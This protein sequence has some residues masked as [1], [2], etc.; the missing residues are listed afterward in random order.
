MIK[1]D[2]LQGK[3]IFDD[4]SERLTPALHS[5]QVEPCELPVH[6]YRPQ[7][8]SA[9]YIPPRTAG[10]LLP[11][12]CH[13]QGPTMLFT[14]RSM[15]LATHPGQISF[16]GGSIENCDVD[17]VAASVRETHEEVGIPPQKI[18]PL[19]VLDNFDTISGYR[20]VPV[21]G[22]VKTPVSLVL[23]SSEVSAAFE[24]PLAEV[25]DRSCYQKRIIEYADCQHTVYSW[26]WQ[27][28]NIWGAT[29]AVLVDLIDKLVAKT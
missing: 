20:M 3:N 26:Q 19:G 23:D 16:P 10:V 27:Q 28:H 14:V 21:V 11:I 29:A 13:P 8:Q 6:G 7:G 4:L 12:I 25:L 15:E 9:D 22:L 1:L 18:T 5:L 2:D 17:E 24:V